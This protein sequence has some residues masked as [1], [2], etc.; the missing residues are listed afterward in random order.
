MAEQKTPREILRDK[1][2]EA[3]GLPADYQDL[4]PE[5]QTT[6]HR[7]RQAAVDA[8]R[9][10]LD[11]AER[12]KQEARELDAYGQLKDAYDAAQRDLGDKYGWGVIDVSRFMD[13]ALS[14]H[15]M[16]WLS[17]SDD[18]LSD[19]QSMKNTED[20]YLAG[21]ERHKELAW[22]KPREGGTRTEGAWQ[23][24][25]EAIETL[26]PTP[27]VEEDRFEGEPHTQ[28]YFPFPRKHWEEKHYEGPETSK[29]PLFE[30][31]SGKPYGGEGREA[32]LRAKAEERSRA[33]RGKG[34]FGGEPSAE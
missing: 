7:E 6:L 29:L 26:S 13:L 34:R 20:Q 1:S 24:R 10:A 16:G 31:P 14:A 25:R 4:S 17:L 32:Q 21:V 27:Q 8:P 30:A 9:E 15:N 28:D 5:R 33:A 23:A 22:G 18:A 3:Q 11:R 2:I 19:F 12:L